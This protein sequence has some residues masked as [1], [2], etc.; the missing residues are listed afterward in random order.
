[1][2]VGITTRVGEKRAEHEA[3]EQKIVLLPYA[4][5]ADQESFKG[6]SS[7]DNGG[8]PSNSPWLN[9]P[10]HWDRPAKPGG[11]SEATRLEQIMKVRNDNFV[12][13]IKDGA[14]FWANDFTAELLRS[15]ADKPTS[16]VAVRYPNVVKA[17]LRL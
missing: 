1:M 16:E 11:V 7:W 17:L 14:V 6:A 3:A 4:Y 15:L 9:C 2:V 13:R 10:G 8:W 5:Y 12:L